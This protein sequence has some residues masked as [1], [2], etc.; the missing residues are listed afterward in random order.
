MGLLSPAL[1]SF[2]RQEERVKG[3]HREIFYWE[4][5][6]LSLGGGAQFQTANSLLHGGQFFKALLDEGGILDAGK[7]GVE[8][9]KR[10]QLIVIAAFDD[11][12]V[13][14][15][16]NLIGVADGAQTVGDD[17]TRAMRHEVFEGL[18]NQFF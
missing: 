6:C 3:C 15:D 11:L 16:E 7:T 17:E 18:L 8:A 12:S 14:E 5:C 4:L 1:S 10:D 13:A 9:V 2:L